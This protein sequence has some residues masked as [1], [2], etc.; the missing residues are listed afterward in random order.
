MKFEKR[1]EAPTT[2]NRFYYKDNAF[3]Q[4]GCGMPN[5]TAYAWGRFYELMDKLGIPGKPKLETSNAENWYFED[6]YYEKGQ[7]PKL[8]SIIVW[9]CGKYHEPSDGRGHVGVVEEIYDNGD[10]LI[11]ASDAGNKKTGYKGKLFYTKKITKSSGYYWASSNYK[12]TFE[13]FI[14]LPKDFDNDEPKPEPKPEPTPTPSEEFKLGDKV[15][16]KGYATAA[17]DGSGSRTANYSG[18]PKDPTDIRYIT[19]IN[20]GAKRPYH[21]SVGK[22]LHNGDRGWVTKE[23]LTK[24][25]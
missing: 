11:S 14:Y 8:G 19:L 12:Y 25:E 5:C 22:T 13:G 23:Q 3:Y 20:R 9:R 6:K 2:D 18:N 16:V 7:T 17:S 4:C 15:C 24:V 1:L 21:I 10:I